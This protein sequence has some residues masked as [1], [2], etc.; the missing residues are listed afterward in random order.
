MDGD[1][2]RVMAIISLSI[3]AAFAWKAALAPILALTTAEAELIAICAC[4]TEVIYVRKLANELGFLQTKPTIVYTD[5]QGVKALAEHTHFK[6]RSKHYQLRRTF[7]QDMVSQHFLVIHYCPR[8]HMIA[9][10]QTAPRPFPVLDAFSKI[11]Y[12]EVFAAVRLHGQ[13]D[14]GPLRSERTRSSERG[15]V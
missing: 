10:V 1:Q 9:D 13:Q 5:N 8:E 2:Y 7:I 6:G 4:A 11:I 12:G 15:G 14:F 3:N